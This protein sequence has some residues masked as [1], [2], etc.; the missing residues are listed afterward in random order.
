MFIPSIPFGKEFEASTHFFYIGVIFLTFGLCYIRFKKYRERV[1]W[2]PLTILWVIAVSRDYVGADYIPY[3]N[4][5]NNATWDGYNP[6]VSTIEPG[7]YYLNALLNHIWSYEYFGFMAIHFLIL[8]FTYKT[9]TYF[10]TD[11]SFAY[12]ILAYVSLWYYLSFNLV[13]ICLAAAIVSWGI[14]FLLEKQYWKYFTIIGLLFFIHMSS[15]V[16]ALPGLAY[17]IYKK[18]PKFTIVGLV[19][20]FAIV[21]GFLYIFLQNVN[22]ERY[23]NYI[24]MESGTGIGMNIFFTYIPLAYWLYK[25]SNCINK[26][27]WQLCLIFTIFAF[28]IDFSGYRLEILGRLR[29]YAVVPF[30]IYLPVLI[31]KLQKVNKEQYVLNSFAVFVY[32][33]AKYYLLI[34]QLYWSDKIMPYNSMLFE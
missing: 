20:L 11:I 22:I 9:I 6:L 12:A 28:L 32:L 13:R 15:A 8:F 25:G 3:Y 10:K 33:I 30:M 2:L 1:L 16:M 27:L 19:A 29:T 14:R 24:A 26:N 5:F 18:H 21:N 7:F 31:Q 23:Q 34:P 4:I 17:I